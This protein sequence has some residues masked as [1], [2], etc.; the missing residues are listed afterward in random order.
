MFYLSAD[1]CKL[2]VLQKGIITSGSVNVFDVKFQFDSD[3][4]DMDQQ[5]GRAHV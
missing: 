1:K 2:S 5:I 3:W 4:G